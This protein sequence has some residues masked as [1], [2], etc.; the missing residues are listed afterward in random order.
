[1]KNKQPDSKP[2]G[3]HREF[4]YN[5]GYI[6]GIGTFVMIIVGRVIIYFYC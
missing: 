4:K 1:M 5:A 6:M 3:F 2:E